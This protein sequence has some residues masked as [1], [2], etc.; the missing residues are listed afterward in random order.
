[1]A[2]ETR[3]SRSIQSVLLRHTLADGS[4]HLDWMIE[5]VDPA[6]ALITFRLA[7]ESD[8]MR[9]GEIG[10]ER[11]ADHRRDYLEYEGIITGGRGSVKRIAE[12]EAFE[13]LESE[14]RFSV[15]LQ[16]AGT[17]GRRMKWTGERE[18]GPRWKFVGVVC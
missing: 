9:A 18:N 8:L 15:V 5:R 3:N 16:S 13:L 10:A 2:N 7:L 11:I 14:D 4:A 1:M 6:S 17:G 12:F